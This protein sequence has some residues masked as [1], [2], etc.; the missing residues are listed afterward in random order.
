MID[1]QAGLLPCGFIAK[2]VYR[3]ADLSPCGFIANGGEILP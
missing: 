1:R 2:R 3:Q